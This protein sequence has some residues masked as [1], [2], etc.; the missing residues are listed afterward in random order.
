MDTHFENDPLFYESMAYKAGYRLV[1]GVDEAGRGPLAGP[2]V[3]AA[4]IIPVG[5]RLSGIKDSKKLTER[6]REKAFSLINDRALAISIGVVSPK[7]IDEFNIL[8]ATLRAMKQAALALAPSP[9]YLL[10]DGINA[11]PV[12]IP[13]KCLKKGDQLSQ[14][15]SAASIMAKVYRDRI[16]HSYHERYPEYGFSKHKGYGTKHHLAAIE[17]YGPSPI[18]RLTYN[19]CTEKKR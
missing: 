19:G 12:S 10:I 3:A 11:V 9:E 8:K 15:I 18:H 5:E 6:A 2:V 16:M 14:S 13:Q 4:V 7:F 1:A 17:R